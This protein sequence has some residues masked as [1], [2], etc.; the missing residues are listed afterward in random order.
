MAAVRGD[1]VPA[2]QLARVA[3]VGILHGDAD[4]AAVLAHIGELHTLQYRGAG[5]PGT[6]A[7]N[8][9]KSRLV[10]EQ[11]AAG[12]DRL[13]TLVQVRNDVRELATREAIHRDDGA[14]RDEV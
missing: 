11:P 7:Q 9:L 12:A 2:T 14:L 6:V 3:A 13:D 8:R 5:F 10:Q 1:Q 4:A